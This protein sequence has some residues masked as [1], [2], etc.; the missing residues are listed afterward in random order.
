MKE[1][2]KKILR[3]EDANSRI[4]TGNPVF[5]PI[6]GDRMGSIPEESSELGG[7]TYDRL[8]LRNLARIRH[9]SSVIE[10]SSFNEPMIKQ[11]Q[12]KRE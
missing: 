4:I 1:K 7:L 5:L 8:S 12:L 9:N 2:A 10:N 11:I 6:E 3:Q